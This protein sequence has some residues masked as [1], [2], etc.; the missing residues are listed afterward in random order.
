MFH[1]RARRAR[2]PISKGKNEKRTTMQRQFSF[3]TFRFDAFAFRK[4]I[5]LPRSST[6][7][8]S[9]STNSARAQTL[10]PVLKYP[11]CHEFTRYAWPK[12]RSRVYEW[13]NAREFFGSVP[14]GL[15]GRRPRG[16]RRRHVEVRLA[17]TRKSHLL[18]R[19]LATD[20]SKLRG[21]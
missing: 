15:L 10:S 1:S 20:N 18:D 11:P 7:A 12:Y 13:K 9:D 6:I 3:R 2:S 14:R 17:S 19:F 21:K 4:V 16:F 5:A 8:P